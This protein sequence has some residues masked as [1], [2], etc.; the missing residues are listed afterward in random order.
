M[1]F[2]RFRPTLAGL[3]VAALTAAAPAAFAVSLTGAGYNQN[4]DGMGVA[5]TTPPTDW[6][7]LTGNS[8]TSNSTWTSAITANGANSVATMIAAATPLTAITTPTSTNNNGFNAA[9][10]TS[11]TGDRVLATSPTTVSGGALQLTLTNNTGAAITGLNLGFD[12]VRY[13]LTSTANELPG[14]WVFFS[15]NGTSWVNAASLN[16]TIATVPN[17][18]GVTPANGSVNFGSSL[19]IG[20]NVMLRWVDDN[21]A[22]TSPDQIIGLN[23]VVISAVP[24]P[25]VLSLMLGGLALVTGLARR[26]RNC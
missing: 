20:S 8:G 9:R 24:E 10:S 15:L 11:T 19:A 14:Y 6:A 22:Q 26:R 21:A 16:P 5:G 12:T 2:I 25:A 23:N 1:S 13:N 3:M 7:V 18:V 4:F 17:T